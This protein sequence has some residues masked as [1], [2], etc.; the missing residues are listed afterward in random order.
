MHLES[1][2]ERRLGGLVALPCQH[3]PPAE[4]VDHERGAQLAAVGGDR[5]ARPTPAHGGDLE[6]GVALL[7]QK[8]AELAVVEGRPAPRQA[9]ADGA[10]RRR[11]RHAGQLLPDRAGHTHRL[12]PGPGRGARRGGAFA[13]LVAVDEQHVDAAAGQLAG[14]RESREAR[15]AHEHVG[16]RARDRRPLRPPQR[17]APGHAPAR[18]APATAPASSHGGRPARWRSTS[19]RSRSARSRVRR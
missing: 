18:R 11:E 15:P 9:V 4:R 1:A 3:P 8:P 14:D 16:L 12:E 10:V 2:R 7:E 17:G 13:D 19:K 5:A 6:A